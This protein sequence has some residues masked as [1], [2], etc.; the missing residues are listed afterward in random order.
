MSSSLLASIHYPVAFGIF[1]EVATGKGV[2]YSSSFRGMVQ[3]AAASA[4][5]AFVW[6][7]N[8]FDDTSTADNDTSTADNVWSTADNDT[9]TADNVWS[10]AV[11]DTSTADN[12]WSTAVDDTSVSSPEVRP[13]KS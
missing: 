5:I 10:T 2:D 4:V 9:S 6:R 8:A 12:A 3:I 13:F 7:S 11:D 1:A